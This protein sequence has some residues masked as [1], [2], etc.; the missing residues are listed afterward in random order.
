MSMNWRRVLLCAVA[1][2]TGAAALLWNGEMPERA[3]VSRAEAVIGAPLTPMSY[4]GVARRTTRRSV[5]ASAAATNA[6]V[7]TTTVVAAPAPSGPG[8]AQVVNSY[9]QVTYRC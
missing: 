2:A 8:C 4:A 1:F 6:A 7:A 5:A 9:G 3:G